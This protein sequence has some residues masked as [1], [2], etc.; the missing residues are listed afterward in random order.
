VVEDSIHDC[1]RPDDLAQPLARAVSRAVVDD[2]DLLVGIR[3]R[4]DR[5]DDPVYGPISL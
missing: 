2:D 5:C 3:G 1:G 4:A